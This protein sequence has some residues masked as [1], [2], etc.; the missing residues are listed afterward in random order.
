MAL[1]SVSTSSR[2]FSCCHP[3]LHGRLPRPACALGASAA[4]QARLVWARF[5]RWTC[6]VG[7]K[8]QRIIVRANGLCIYFSLIAYRERF[9]SHRAHTL[10]PRPQCPPASPRPTPAARAAPNPTVWLQRQPQQ[11]GSTLVLPQLPRDRQRQRVSEL[12]RI[13]TAHRPGAPHP[14]NDSMA[15]CARLALEK[16]HLTVRRIRSIM[17]GACA[18]C[19][20]RA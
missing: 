4:A 8:L 16:G 20:D 11:N 2:L 7:E 14:L 10:P 13:S 5:S 3:G 1:F 6:Q 18:V 15:P 17:P 19:A 12:D 9:P